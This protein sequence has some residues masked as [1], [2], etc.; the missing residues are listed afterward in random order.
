[1]SKEIFKKPPLTQTICEIEKIF[2]KGSIMQMNSDKVEPIESIS[3][4]SLGLDIALSIGGLPRG[5]IVEIFGPESAGKTTLA[6]HV[7][8][9]AQKSGGTV[10]FIDAENSLDINYAKT[11]GV[12]CNKMLISQPD[13]GEVALNI[14]NLLFEKNAVD[15]VVV[16]S[17]A[18]LAPLAELNGDVGDSYVGIHARMMNQALRKQ[19]H[20]VYKSNAILIYINQLREKVGITFGNNEVTPGG[21]GLKFFTSVR[22][23]VRKTSELIKEN[24]QVVGVKTNVRI[25]KSKICSPYKTVSFDI[26]YGKGISK[27]SEI[28][29]L[30][31]SLNLIKKNG[32]WY[33]YNNQQIGQGRE[34]AREFLLKHPDLAHELELTI[35]KNYNLSSNNKK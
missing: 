15:L 16:D 22:L 10:A 6:L 28:L 23:D 32:M 33:S 26:L 3:T 21:K 13:S 19:S 12:D 11:I 27:V 30:A 34:K 17:V 31:V 24:D 35:R 5:R 18:A 20:I 7:I 14:A 25:V 8:A 2:G 29:D 1:M 4:G 9:E